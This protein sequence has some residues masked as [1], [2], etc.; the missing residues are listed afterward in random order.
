MVKVFP[1][2]LAGSSLAVAA[3]TEVDFNR[4]VRPILSD[5][6][7]SCH[8][9]DAESRKADLRLDTAEGATAPHDGVAAIVPG[10]PDASELMKRITTEDADEV[11]PPVK[12]KKRLTEVQK[13]VL[14]RWIA[15]GAKYER[16]WAFEPPR[17]SARPPAVSAQ[18]KP[19]AQAGKTGAGHWTPGT[20]PI[21]AFI[22]AR[23]EKEGLTPSPEAD[24]A[25][26]CRRL[27]L[28]LTGLPP[29]PEE[30]DAFLRE[31]RGEHRTDRQGDNGRSADDAIARL[32]G[33][34]LG[35]PHYG[36]RWGRHWL[37]I[38]RYADSNG[39]DRNVI[40]QHAW[41]YRDYVIASFNRD[42]P[43]DEFIR[44]Q[45]AGD[46]IP[47]ADSVQ[48]DERLTATA[49]LALGAKAYEEQKPEV[50]R[51]DVIDEQIEVISRGVLGLSVACA[52]C[53]DHKFDPIPTADYCSLAGIL[54][55]TQPLYGYGP[56][57][58]K[59]TAFHHTEWHAL[60][61][62]A[63]KLAPAALEYFRRLDAETLAMHTARS[64][65]YRI[66]RRLPDAK[67][68]IAAASPAE[69][70]EA[71]AAL[72]KMEAEIAGWNVKIAALEKAV[73]DL[74]DAAP[75]QP[76]WT[77]GARDRE[78]I[79]DCRIHI[80]GETTNLGAAVPRGFLQVI[81][82]RDAPR[83]AAKQSGRL[84]LAQWLTHRENPLTARVFVNRVWQK[85]MGRALVTTPDDFGVNGARPS[86]PELLDD[87]AVRF[88]EHGW[89]VKWLVREIVTSRTYRMSSDADAEAL[90]RD[91][92][93]V[94]HWRSAPRV[95]DAEVLRDCILAMSGQLDPQPPREQFLARFHPQRDAELHTFK[96]FLTPEMIVDAH[97]SVYLPVVRGTL[98]EMFSL[99]DDA[100]RVRRLHVLA[101]SRE[102][103]AD[104]LSRTLAFV[105]VPEDLIADPKA[106]SPAAPAQL[107]EARWTSLCQMMMASAEFRMAR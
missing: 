94:L 38:A 31:W 37:D 100:S 47:A 68:R 93:N 42:K 28:D 101:F 57:G 59:A 21:D 87:L 52:R 50:F 23:L 11:M 55:S 25:T 17:R 35:S 72:K 20:N 5:H 16:H 85:L 14:R 45:I 82:M 9:F 27:H 46:L 84:E 79:E 54:R 53:H 89:S 58:I 18:L 26:L 62:D 88:M 61:P 69:K 10:K 13:D 24:P 30:A 81:A 98:P 7:F 78:K 95:L 12:S 51:M 77:M 105:G 56:R 106:K 19:G 15:Q 76:G 80:R 67:A 96:P 66:Q 63:E 36:E 40:F 22:L 29:T 102:P 64:D 3:T 39:R 92:D 32:T 60:G 43:L 48:R 49:F 99:A 73:A 103:S 2:L 75:P 83:P 34:L 91:P 71:E 8:G 41:R 107:R 86:H 74:Q 44:E 90:R 6:C 33:K 65:R 1:V 97:R 104:E 4:D 70:P